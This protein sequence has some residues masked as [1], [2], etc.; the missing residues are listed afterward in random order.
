MSRIRDL[1]LN[2]DGLDRDMMAIDTAFQNKNPRHGR[3]R[4][5]R[6]CGISRARGFSFAGD[7]QM[8]KIEVKTG[9]RYG[10]LTVV[11]EVEPDGYHR[12]FRCLC[13]C[14]ASKV[15]VLKR[16]RNGNTASCGCLHRE[17]SAANGREKPATTHGHSYHPIYNIWRGMINRCERPSDRYYRN[18]GGRGIAVCQAWHDAGTFIEWAHASGWRDG[19]QIDRID[20]DGNYSPENCRF[21][22]RKENCRNT[23]HNV[24][25]TFREITKPLAAWAE[26]FGLRWRTLHNRIYRYDWTVE[27]ALTLPLQRGKK[28]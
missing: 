1:F 16:L 22:T 11:E 9:D 17:V 2:T 6:P 19:L 20:N 28:P 24:L 25:V 3:S 14:G 18:Y 5:L 15:A 4:A 23:R 10:R 13:D 12:R 8:G 7:A 26:Q 21:V 27:Q